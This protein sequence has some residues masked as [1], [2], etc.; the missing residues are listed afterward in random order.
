M[1]TS[2]LKY[3]IISNKKDMK[4][5]NFT[6]ND[7]T[8]LE[9]FLK[10]IVKTEIMFINTNLGLEIYY[11]SPLNIKKLI[12]SSLELI[13]SQRNIDVSTYQ[14]SSFINSEE[15]SNHICHN[16][17]RLNSMPLSYKCYIQS[18]FRQ[19]ELNKTKNIRVIK[20]LIDIWYEIIA[21][22]NYNK[23]IRLNFIKPFNKFLIENPAVTNNI[24]IRKPLIKNSLSLFKRN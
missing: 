4:Y 1:E 17:S 16:F 5:L 23:N 21:S 24:E 11:L 9:N 8:V 22:P 7:I 18:L 6:H 15:I 13:N 20:E 14:I 12:I 2:L 10:G 3:L 19:I